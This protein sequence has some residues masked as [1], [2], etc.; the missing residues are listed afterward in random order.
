MLQVR[1]S[2]THRT[3]HSRDNP[4]IIQVKATLYVG[5]MQAQNLL[6]QEWGAVAD[7]GGIPVKSAYSYNTRLYQARHNLIRDYLLTFTLC[8]LFGCI[9]INVKV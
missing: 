3:T 1:M 2:H 6:N 8:L 5:M 9:K 7:L 4:A